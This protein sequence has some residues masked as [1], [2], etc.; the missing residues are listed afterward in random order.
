MAVVRDS[1]GVNHEVARRNYWN[2]KVVTQCGREL[3]S[4]DRMIMAKVTCPG[5]K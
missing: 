3:Q 2:G 1:N 5:C 4:P